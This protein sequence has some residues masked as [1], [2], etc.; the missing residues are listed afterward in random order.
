MLLM[1]LVYT[2]QW[3]NPYKLFGVVTLIKNSSYNKNDIYAW[4]R[5]IFVDKSYFICNKILCSKWWE[6]ALLMH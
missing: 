2:L 6:Q 3:L 5:F 1:F 4:Y